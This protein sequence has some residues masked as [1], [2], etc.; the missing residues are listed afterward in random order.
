M[1]MTLRFVAAALLAAL[2]GLGGPARA[3]SAAPAG[4]AAKGKQLFADDGCYQC[5][6][7]VGQGG[8]AGLRLGPPPI[9]YEAFIGQLRHP[10]AEMPPYEAKLLPDKDAADIYAYLQTLPKPPSVKDVPLLNNL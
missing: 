3:Q 6:G 4:D 2:L 9:A 8:N 10:R 7:Y 1:R 5:H